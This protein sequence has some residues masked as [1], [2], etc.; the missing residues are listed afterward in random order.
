MRTTKFRRGGQGVRLRKVGIAVAAVLALIGLFGGY[1]W[2]KLTGP[3]PEARP[4]VTIAQTAGT[5]NEMDVVWPVE[6]TTMLTATAQANGSLVWLQGNGDTTGSET[7]DLTPRSDRGAE[8]KPTELRANQI[9][10]DQAD[11]LMRLNSFDADGHRSTL[12]VLQAVMPGPGPVL[13]VGSGLD[14]VDPL[15]FDA[16]GFDAPISEVVE[17][18]AANNELPKGLA[19]RD[20]WLVFTPTAGDQAPLRS[21]HREYR[22]KLFEAIVVAGGGKV[23]WAGESGAA[24]AGSGGTAA[25]VPVPPAPE[26]F[27]PKTEKVPTTQVPGHTVQRCVLPAGVLFHGDKP[28]LLD[29]ATAKAMVRTCLN[30]AGTL[31]KVELIGHTARTSTTTAPDN[32]DAMAL[33]KGRAE[34][35]AQLVIK[36]GIHPD[37]VSATG[38]GATKPLVNPPSDPANRAVEVLVTYNA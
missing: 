16:L 19:G 31:T 27:T 6:V 21:P 1:Q 33:S 18:L 12:A 34:R 20:V 23:H 5:T 4:V 26:T 8:I 29:E 22:A 24:P 13:V 7:L 15:R 11:L 10:T 32:P 37:K 35:V 38:V 3:E 14:T 36:M 17:N 25:V 9:T 2:W 28:D 30:G